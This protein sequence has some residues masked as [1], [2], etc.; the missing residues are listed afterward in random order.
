M[1]TDIVHSPPH[2]LGLGRF[3][4]RGPEVSLT[5]KVFEIG[6]YPDRGFAIDASEM[7]SAIDRFTPVANDLEHSRLRDVLGN[8]LGELRRLWRV[9]N[10]VFGEVAVPK[11]LADLTGNVL[12]VSLAFDASK[13]VVGNALTLSPRIGDA[14]VAAAFSIATGAP[15]KNWFERLVSWLG[16]EPPARFTAEAK[17]AGNSR[18]NVAASKAAAFA[19]D[20][21]RTKKFLP[22]DRPF[23]AKAFE[24][25]FLADLVGEM[26]PGW[27]FAESEEGEAC[28]SL[29]QMVEE[30]PA[31]GLDQERLDG[32]ERNFAPADGVSEDRLNELLGKT[33]LGREVKKARK[34]KA[35]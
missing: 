5:G 24:A 33:D 34:S 10:D 8:S 4:D 19:D 35:L 22:V 21:V 32:A 25:A 1:K 23:L 29:R 20:A 18:T 11:W 7:D 16:A 27:Q 31:H 12:K 17:S 9:G 30:R 15:T 28:A 2:E 3:S 6:D 14:E 13:R 26:S